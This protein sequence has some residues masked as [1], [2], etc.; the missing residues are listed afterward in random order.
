[1]S[2][3]LLFLG[4]TVCPAL[5]ATLS[6]ENGTKCLLCVQGSWHIG[7]IFKKVRKKIE[8]LQFSLLESDF[9]A[10]QLTNTLVLEATK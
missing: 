4:L 8:F 7:A 3:L 6:G 5:W 10:I 9:L 1:M 2:I